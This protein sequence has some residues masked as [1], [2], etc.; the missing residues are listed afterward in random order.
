VRCA[1]NVALAALGAPLVQLAERPFVLPLA[2]L[3][4]RRRWGLVARLG[5][6]GW[7]RDLAA[8]VLLDYTLY[9]WHV[10]LHR[11]AWLWRFHLVH[12]VDLELD[13]STGLRF[14]AGELLASVPWRAG[15]VLLI[16][17]GPR[18]VTAWESL[19]VVSVMFHHSNVELP[20]AVER[21]LSRFVVTPRM[22]AVHH[23]IVRDETDS[24]FSSGLTL[25]DRLHRTLRLNVPQEAI[26]IGVPAY[27]DP[28]G[29]GLSEILEMPFVA[30]RPSWQLPGNG[31]PVREPHPGPPDRLAP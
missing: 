1:R 7:A 19:L 18:A 2:R 29:L 25:W 31:T 21:V 20:I 14:H 13:A 23:S 4:A 27:R 22:H 28:G 12:H 17:A 26:V 10:L 16:G 3:V 9:L 15:Q 24:N 6:P 8:I 11:T 30:D 5:L